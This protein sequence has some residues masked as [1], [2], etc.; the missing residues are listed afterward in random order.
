MKT[1]RE[2]E[3]EPSETMRQATSQTGQ[4]SAL[5]GPRNPYGPL[6][7]IRSDSMADLPNVDGNALEDISVPTN[8][9]QNL[10]LMLKGGTIHK[11]AL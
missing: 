3:F 8:P 7:V 4:L 11:N 6:G 1:A 5:R 2:M 9:T 10:R